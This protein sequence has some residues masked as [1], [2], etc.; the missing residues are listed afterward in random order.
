[1]A[2]V[3]DRI[4]AVSQT[5][6]RISSICIGDLACLNGRHCCAALGM[7]RAGGSPLRGW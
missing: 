3:A 4:F 2:Q 5:T 1:V 7:S 6:K